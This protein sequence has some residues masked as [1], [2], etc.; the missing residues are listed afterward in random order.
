[1][2]F[3]FALISNKIVSASQRIVTSMDC[4]V[5]NHNVKPWGATWYGPVG[6]AQGGSTSGSAGR[7]FEFDCQRNCI[8]A[9]ADWGSYWVTCGYSYKDV[10]DLRDDTQ[11]MVDVKTEAFNHG[12]GECGDGWTRALS[13]DSTGWSAIDTQGDRGHYG[14]HIC[15]RLEHWGNVKDSRVEVITDLMASTESSVSD[16]GVKCAD[17]NG[18]CS[19]NGLVRYG[20]DGH[21]SHWEDVSVSINCNAGVFGDPIWGTVKAC[22]CKEGG[23]AHIGQW[24]T[25]NRGT[26]LAYG[27]H[28]N[29]KDWLHFYMTKAT[30]E[31]PAKVIGQWLKKT[32]T[33]PLT[34]DDQYVVTKHFESSESS[35]ATESDM[36]NWG[37]QISESSNVEVAVEA[38]ANYGAY[39]AGLESRYGYEYEHTRSETFQSYLQNIASTTFSQ[40]TTVQHTYTIPK[41]VRGEPNYFNIWYFQTDVISRDYESATHYALSSGVQTHGCGYSI[42]PNCLPGFCQAYDPHCW[43]CTSAAAIIDPDFIPPP[44]CADE[45]EGCTWNPVSATECPPPEISANVLD[46]CTE[47]MEHGELCEADSPL[48]NGA[49]HDINNCGDYDVFRFMCD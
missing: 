22:Y 25:D 45:G 48:P 49:F 43:E 26:A 21:F 40:S 1:M 42:A 10:D 8:D 23:F 4:E 29:T 13:L 12:W 9:D 2:I 35:E 3:A 27:N 39:E 32:L 16:T 15:Y 7:L 41:R 14:F 44:E 18:Q 38:S 6:G 37:Q 17:E 34:S 31:L 33:R 30:P 47:A 19:C 5:V 11:V 36:K 20:A 46:G 28:D 24:D